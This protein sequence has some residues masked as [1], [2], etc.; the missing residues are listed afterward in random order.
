MALKR[1]ITIVVF[2]AL[3]WPDVETTRRD[4]RT[5]ATRLA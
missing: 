5:V 2:A 1:N 4:S 3:T